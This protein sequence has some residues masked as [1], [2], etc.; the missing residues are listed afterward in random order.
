VHDFD[1]A[2]GA[3]DRR[4]S[5]REAPLPEG[6]RLE[7]HACPEPQRAAEH[8]YFMYHYKTRKCAGFPWSCV[9]DGFDYHFGLSLSLSLSLLSLS[10]LWLSLSLFLRARRG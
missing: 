6:G 10:S 2:H 3:G 4:Q 1:Q 8:E 7:L 9:C 5:V